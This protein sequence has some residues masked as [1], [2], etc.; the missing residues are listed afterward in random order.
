MPSTLSHEEA[1]LPTTTILVFDFIFL[2][3][4]HLLVTRLRTGF[5]DLPSVRTLNTFER[6]E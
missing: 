1:P 4:S 6:V 2:F 3:V 5:H